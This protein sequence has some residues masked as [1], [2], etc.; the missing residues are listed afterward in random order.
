MTVT[1]IRT[2]IIYIFIILALRVTGKRQIGELQPVELVV[3]LLISDLAAIP[4]Q[5]NG[6]PLISGLIPIAI[7]VSLELL[8]SSLMMKSTRLSQVINGN[9]VVIIKNGKLDQQTLRK[10]RLGVDDV[11]EAMRQ[12][13]LFDIRQ[14]DCAIAETNG[15]I[16]FF[17]KSKTQSA[18]VPIINDGAAVSWGME[19]CG[20][21][22]ERLNKIIQKNHCT[23]K[24]ILLMTADQNGT[25]V[26]VRKEDDA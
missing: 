12:Q 11:T 13:E 26:I 8:L 14:I 25:I 6:V 7:L 18:H 23:F 16:S 17:E 24:N 5:D 4:M 21:S 15:R 10:L 2:V 19:F 3:T 22:P 20:I 9:P 1:A